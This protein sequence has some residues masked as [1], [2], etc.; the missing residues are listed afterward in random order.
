L[1][2]KFKEWF[3][4]HYRE[5]YQL[6]K[7]LLVPGNK[8]YGPETC[9][10]VT[11]EINK[12]LL[13]RGVRSGECPIGV[14]KAGKRFRAVLKINGI[15][16]DL[17]VFN[18]PEQAEWKYAHAKINKVRDMCVSLEARLEDGI[19]SKLWE[20]FPHIFAGEN[21]YEDRPWNV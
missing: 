1:A 15:K 3:D 18:T 2:S 7:D 8:T 9:V 13:Y 21:T 19:E 6:D 17:G 14:T 12:I 16:Q 20:R 5:G 4:D 10:F 11:Q